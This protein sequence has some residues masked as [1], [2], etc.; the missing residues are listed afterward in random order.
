MGK[1][2]KVWCYNCGS[3]KHMVYDPILSKKDAIKGDSR[4]WWCMNCDIIMVMR[5]FK[6]YNK[7]TS[8]KQYVFRQQEPKS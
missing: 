1:I 3:R 5:E 8:A 4:V 6:V 7:V 2:T